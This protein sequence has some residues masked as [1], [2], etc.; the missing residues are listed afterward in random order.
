[1]IVPHTAGSRQDCFQL[2]RKEFR[3]AIRLACPAAALL[4]NFFISDK[5]AFLSFYFHINSDILA[6]YR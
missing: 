5:L 2:R 3:T 1:M 4:V 6:T